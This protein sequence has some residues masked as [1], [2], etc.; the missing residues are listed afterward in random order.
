[1]R[2]HS[3]RPSV[4]T[5]ISASTQAL[6]NSPAQNAISEATTMRGVAPKIVS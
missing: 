3:P 1:M 2:A 5:F 4:F 6:T